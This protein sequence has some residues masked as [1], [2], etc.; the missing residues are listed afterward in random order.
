[1]FLFYL[2]LDFDNFFLISAFYQFLFLS[3]LNITFFEISLLVNFF[4]L[5]ILFP[6]LHYWF[7]KYIS[8]DC[9][10]YYF[11]GL[12]NPYSASLWFYSSGFLLNLIFLLFPSS[13]LFRRDNSL[14]L[15]PAYSITFGKILFVPF[16][17]IDHYNI[18]GL[19]ANFLDKILMHIHTKI[20]RRIN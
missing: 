15:S 7:Y 20:L 14:L 8:F 9:L 10:N 2:N 13:F 12:R 6:W 3:N 16:H 4:L 19:I 18:F 5:F 11:Y 17:F 1:M